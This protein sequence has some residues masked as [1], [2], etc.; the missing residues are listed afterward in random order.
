[1]RQYTQLNFGTNSASDMFQNIISEQIRDIPGTIN[2]SDD[3]IVFVKTQAEHNKALQAVFERFSTAGLSLNKTKCEFNRNSLTFFGV[4]FSDKGISPDPRNVRAIQDAKPSTSNQGVRNFLGLAT[5]CAKFIPSFR[6]ISQPLRELT[7]KDVLFIWTKVHGQAFHKIKRLLTSKAIMAHFD[8]LKKKK[9]ITDAS[10]VGL[11]AI[12]FQKTPGQNNRKVV[13]YA[14]RS[15]SDVESLYSQMGKD[16]L[17]IVW[18]IE[19]LHLY[20]Y[21]GCFT[22]YTDCKPVQLILETLSPNLQHVSN[23]GICDYKDTISQ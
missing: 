3:V 9:L 15:L 21:G 10:P 1:M 22:L 13:A 7:K 4:I 20:L 2:I 17:A 19:R 14:S 5:Y 12:L 16:A 23:G 18:A 6:D 8:Q 11:A